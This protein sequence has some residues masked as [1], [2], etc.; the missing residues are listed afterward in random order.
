MH[1][2]HLTPTHLEEGYGKNAV[3]W[4]DLTSKCKRVNS[5]GGE[6][7]NDDDDDDDDDNIL[8]S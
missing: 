1:I 8:F 5:R 2:F 6:D 3:E 4:A 7:N